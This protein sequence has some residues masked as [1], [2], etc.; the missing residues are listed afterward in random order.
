MDIGLIGGDMKSP[1]SSGSGEARRPGRNVPAG[2][3][4]LRP[5]RLN[6]SLNYQGFTSGRSPS[7]N[8]YA[9]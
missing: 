3:G 4:R 1:S 6:E 7:G 5:Q 8:G 2:A 9:R